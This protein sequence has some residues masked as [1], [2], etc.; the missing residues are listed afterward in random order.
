MGVKRDI[1]SEV[2]ARRGRQWKRIPRLQQTFRRLEDLTGALGL[3][4]KSS[5]PLR[6]RRELYRYFPIALIA[7]TEGHMRM[8]YRDLI[9][10]GEPYL[11]RIT[12]FKDLRIDSAALIATASKH[13]SVGELIAHQLSH[14][15]L[16]DIEFN[17]STLLNEDFRAE[18]DKDLVREDTEG[19]HRL[20]QTFL[21]RFVAD[22]F[23]QR[24]IFCHE[25]ATIFLPKY[26]TIDKSLR[27][28]WIFLVMIEEHV[29]E[30]DNRSGH[31]EAK[32]A[33]QTASR[34]GR[35]EDSEGGE[36]NGGS[37]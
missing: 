33:L 24:H 36:A 15:N 14:N 11:P 17:L 9:N 21:R 32:R 22:T 3:L 12:E 28:F 31:V 5:I 30:R 4:K 7:I 10:L 29:A 34:A 13:V 37:R 6:Y 18:F 26:L 20:F 23:K 16:S 35:S 25:L 19:G 8:L 2:L 27:L 1:I